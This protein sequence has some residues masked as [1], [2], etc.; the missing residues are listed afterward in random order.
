VSIFIEPSAD[1]AGLASDR[2]QGERLAAA[3]NR[4]AEPHRQAVVMHLYSGLTFEQMGQVL[5]EPLATVASRYRRALE[6]LRQQMRE[7]T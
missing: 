4:L 2:E 7:A 6:D 1:P 5:G 3:L